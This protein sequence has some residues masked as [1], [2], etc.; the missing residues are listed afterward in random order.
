ML[1]IERQFVRTERP[2]YGHLVSLLESAIASGELPS[3]TRVPPERDARAA[4]EDQPHHRRQRLSRARVARAAARLRRARH[5]RVRG[6]GARR[7]RRSRGA[8]RSPPR[9]CARATR[10]CATSCGNSSDARLLSLAA[11][12]PALDRF[13][14]RGV[15]RGGRRTCCATDPHVGVGARPDAKG[16][17]R[18]ASAIAE[19]YGVPRE[20][21]L[22]LSGA[23]QGLDLLARCLIDPGDAVIIDRP[24]LSGRDPVVPRGRREV[25]RLGHRAAPTATSSRICSSAIGRS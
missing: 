9:R 6:A 13:P 3:G 22:V 15:P 24:G 7:G 12:E 19:R 2:L 18:C 4:A 17:R 14:E 1:S 16:S 10:R 20:S 23:Q 11:G 21:V 25:D 5:V 8:E